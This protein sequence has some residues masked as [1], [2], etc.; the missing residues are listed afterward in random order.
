MLYP[1][2]DE[3]L[4]L[5]SKAAQSKL[6]FK[7]KAKSSTTG[8]YL[9][10]FR[11]QGMEFD[12][13]RKYV[14]GDDIR[15]IDWRIT[16]RA[17]TPHIKLFK[18]ERQ[19]NILLCVD[20]NH[21]MRFGTRGTFKSVQAAR[22]AAIL[23]W[24]ANNN[25]DAIG[26][27]LFGDLPEKETFFYPKRSRHS[28]WQMLQTL[29]KP[30]E[31]INNGYVQLSEPVE[32]LHKTVK[33]GSLVFIISDFI[34]I[35]DQFQQQLCYLARKSQIILVSVNDV[36]DMDIPQSGNILFS[37]NEHQ[38]LHISTDNHTGRKSYRQQWQRN[39]S[40]LNEIAAGL[41]INIIE[42]RTDRDAYYDLFQGLKLN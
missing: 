42:I 19:L 33:S 12:E 24:C 36:A 29:A 22:C 14:I 9:S 27:Y 18:E 26:A 2:F 39:R 20:M 32:F 6:V 37:A 41:G 8:D 23:G 38:K 16:A 10:P 7:K 28:L 31:S 25:S 11:G 13:V 3:L 34:N 35:D 4:Q 17:G 1:D 30:A 5:R 21:T 15:K 40:R